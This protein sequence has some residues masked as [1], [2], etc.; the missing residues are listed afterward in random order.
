[1]APVMVLVQEWIRARPQ[2]DFPVDDGSVG[3]LKAKVNSRGGIED[4]AMLTSTCSQMPYLG[5]RRTDDCLRDGYQDRKTL[6]TP[7]AVLVVTRF[8]AEKIQEVENV[9]KGY[10]VEI[11]EVE[12]RIN[13]ISSSMKEIYMTIDTDWPVG[14]YPRP[15]WGIVGRVWRKRANQDGVLFG[16]DDET[17]PVAWVHGLFSLRLRRSVERKHR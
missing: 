13:L 16:C 9:Y 1:M 15:K 7:R 3:N 11:F 8:I 10:T 14:S 2:L 5:E 17:V 6:P 12:F 4:A